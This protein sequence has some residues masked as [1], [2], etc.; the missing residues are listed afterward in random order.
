MRIRAASRTADGIV[1]GVSFAV[2]AP[3]AKGVSLIGDFNHWDGDEAPMRV[4]GSTGVWELFWPGFPVGGHYKFRVH[5][6]DGSVSRPR[7]PDGIRHRGA[8]AD[9][10]AGDH[11]RLHLERRRMDDPAR[12]A[13]SGVRADEHLRGAPD[14]VAAGSQLSPARR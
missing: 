5:G 14:V 10:V 6:A 2:W 3:N 9:G 1:E 4:L 13:Q 11:E 8:A 7:R 12:A